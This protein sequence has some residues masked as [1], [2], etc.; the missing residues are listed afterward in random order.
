MSSN[1]GSKKL[2]ESHNCYVDLAKLAKKHNH[3]ASM[4]EADSIGMLQSY[5]VSRPSSKWIKK[6]DPITWWIG[7]R[8][9]RGVKE[10]TR[11]LITGLEEI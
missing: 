4:S 3:T 2:Q 7:R 1:N 9:T 11:S 5:N 8:T 10:L 6:L